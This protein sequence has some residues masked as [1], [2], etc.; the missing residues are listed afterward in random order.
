MKIN[1]VKFIL[2]FVGITEI[3]FTCVLWNGITCWL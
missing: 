2:F 3:T 1:A